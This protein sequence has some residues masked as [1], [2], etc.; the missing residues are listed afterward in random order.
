M[1][2]LMALVSAIAIWSPTSTSGAS[3]AGSLS[4]VLIAHAGSS[5]TLYVA[6]E[7]QSC[8]SRS[9]LRI[10]RSLNGGESFTS[11]SVPDVSTIHGMNVPSLSQLVFANPLDGYAVQATDTGAKWLSNV[12]FETTNGGRTWRTGQIAPHAVIY[13]IATSQQYWYAI[14]AH[15]T[16]KGACTGEHLYRSRVASKT[17]TRLSNPPVI[18]KYWG[19]NVSIAAY[20]ANVWLTTQ[21][22]FT[23][24]YSPFISISHDRGRSFVSKVEKALSSAANCGLEPSSATHLWAVCGQGMNRGDIVQS[25]DGG[26]TWRATTT[27]PLFNFGFGDFET[28]GRAGAIFADQLRGNGL[29][30][31]SSEFSPPLP[32]A[33]LPTK[34]YWFALS[35]TNAKQGLALSQGPRGSF[36]NQLWATSDAGKQWLRVI[37]PR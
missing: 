17:W 19:G 36:P 1:N 3:N 27:G 25:V 33:D 13:Q 32:F 21:E 34:N 8:Q 16:S 9:C 18:S 11:V 26:V 5:N 15:C 12:L 7:T 23:P 4:P 2:F 30:R 14:T 22:Q 28:V 10:A 29:Y 24:P 37:A 31:V 20:G 35:F 6:W